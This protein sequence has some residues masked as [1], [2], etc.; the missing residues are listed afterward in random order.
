[1]T[2][3]PISTLEP[4]GT[5]GSA[6]L[7]SYYV[8]IV[9]CADGSLYA[10]IATDVIRRLAEHNGGPPAGQSSRT[11]GRGARYTSA[12]RPVALVYQSRCA[13]RS[14]AL[15]EEARIKRLPRAKKQ[16]LIV[17]AMCHTHLQKY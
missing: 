12:R 2:D 15:R 5:A 1:M 10:G 4:V 17:G 13:S 8:Y 7:L 9:Q 14:D 3:D 16:R 11:R 6:A